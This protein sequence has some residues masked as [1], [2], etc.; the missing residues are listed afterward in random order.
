LGADLQDKRGSEGGPVFALL[1]FDNIARE[2]ALSE[3][4]PR[5]G[6]TRKGATG[7]G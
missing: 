1:V 3:A 2:G 5:A 4:A 6:N 7:R